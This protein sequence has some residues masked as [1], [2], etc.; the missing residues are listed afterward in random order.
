MICDPHNLSA[1]EQE[2]ICRGWVRQVAK[3]VGPTIDVPAPDVMTTPAAHALDAGRVGDDP[4]P[5]RPGLHHRQAGRHGRLA[6]THGGDGLRRRLH[7]PRG[8]QAARPRRSTKTKAAVQG[9]GNVS[10]YAIQLYTKM[11]GTVVVGLLVGPGGPDVLHVPPRGSGVDGA[12]LMTITDPFG[13]IDKKKAKELGYEVKPGGDWIAEDVDILIPAA[14]REPGHGREREAD[15]AAAS[16][17][18][19]KART[20]RRRP[21]RTPC[22]RSA[23]SS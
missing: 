9:F 2:G 13:G 16:R 20:D 15:L 1:R 11:G 3:N 14:H 8:A 22:S 5:P 12:E 19:S 7:A 18:S 4:R 6:R 17:S 23:G 10:Q 21:R